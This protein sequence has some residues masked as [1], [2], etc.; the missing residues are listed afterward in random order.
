[1]DPPEIP[2]NLPIHYDSLAVRNGLTNRVAFSFHMKKKS[3][4]FYSDTFPTLHSTFM[5]KFKKSIDPINSIVTTFLSAMML[6][7]LFVYNA[8]TE[9]R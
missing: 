9:F 2:V 5:S 3:L 8:L 4:I 7:L 1:M 6:M